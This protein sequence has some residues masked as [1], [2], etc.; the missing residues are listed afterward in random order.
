MIELNDTF[1]LGNEPLFASVRLLDRFLQKI[2]INPRHLQLV[3]TTCYFIACKVSEESVELPTLRELVIHVEWAFSVNDIVR[4][5][6]IICSKLNWDI[7]VASEYTIMHALAEHL[8]E[9][10]ARQ[11]QQPSAPASPARGSSG[12]GGGGMAATMV[13][14]AATAAAVAA[15]V[16]SPRRGK[17]AA[18]AAAV[19]A[20]EKAAASTDV[21][22]GEQASITAQAAVHLRA[23]ISS[24]ASLSYKAS[25]LAAVALALALKQRW[26]EWSAGAAEEE[27]ERVVAERSERVEP[28]LRKLAGV[29]CASF[30]ECEC[31]MSPKCARPAA[32]VARHAAAN[33]VTTTRRVSAVA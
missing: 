2:R 31:V 25:T 11:Q 7:A 33:A 4:M 17:T 18:A 9:Q 23:F 22:R 28:A 13:A 19:A 5:E 14:S 6:T 21:F 3:A 32:A 20:V 30:R 29:E 15:E 12:G 27:A 1:G 10:C 24:H 26:K 8:Q 16:K